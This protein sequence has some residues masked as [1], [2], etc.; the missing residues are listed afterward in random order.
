MG[1]MSVTNAFTII[2][3][4]IVGLLAANPA[5]IP[6]TWQPYVFAAITVISSLYHLNQPAPPPTP[7]P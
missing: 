5:L 7:K 4:G 2:A 6:P 1:N 3:T